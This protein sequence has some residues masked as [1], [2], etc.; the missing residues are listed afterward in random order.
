MSVRVR[1]APSPT[2][3]LHI[4]GARTALFNWLFARRHQGAFLLRIEDTDVERS[5]S[6][7][8]EGILQGLQWLELDWDE[9]PYYQSQRLELYRSV[10]ARLLREGKAYRDFGAS[11][12]PAEE[13]RRFRDLSETEAQQH[14]A[15]GESF[16]VRFK[17]PEGR[18][19]QFQDRV[20]GS[21]QVESDQVEDFVLLRSD[22][23]PTYHL[24]VVADD[25]D[26]R[27]SHIIRGADHLSN[28]SK[29]VLLYQALEH[30]LPEYAHLPLILGP[31]RRRL[32]KRHG[33][34]SV[35]EYRDQ[36]FLPEAVRNYLAL[37]GW[38]PGDD[39]EL[40]GGQ[41][42]IASFDLERINKANAIFDVQKLEWMNGQYLSR[43]DAET[44]A[45]RLVPHLREGGLW[46][47]HWEKEERDRLLA[48]V[49]LLKPA[50]RKLTDFGEFGRAFF[51]DD[52]AYQEEGRVR[53]LTPADPDQRQ[54]LILA[55]RDLKD[56]YSGLQPFDLQTTEKVLREIAD[57][58]GI[59]TR[60]FI[61][62]VRVALTGQ[63]VAPGI[64]QV[65]TLLGR[66]R[67]VERLE[68]VL[69]FLS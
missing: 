39:R 57:R 36:G 9:G 13:Y 56:A 54:T 68:R 21:V 48:I 12:A 23:H 46:N 40:M 55:L 37:L 29:H 1:F 42:L 34:T 5:S 28:T 52:F 8:I 45:S 64:F 16:A 49:E 24:S 43:L 41:E 59:K 3:Y 35:L 10:A 11:E 19:I 51:T 53:Y 31:D 38:S 69:E 7:M 50:V 17:V 20:Y 61:G 65:I 33:A 18:R 27:I 30:P 14:M 32:S 25:V 58:R 6:A 67:T 15:R 44:I 62:A 22:G 26:M 4:G 60:D 47:P 66:R 63:P 2:G